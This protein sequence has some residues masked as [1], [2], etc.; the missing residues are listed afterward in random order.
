MSLS[1]KYHV[2]GITSSGQKIEDTPVVRLLL[3]RRD[4]HKRAV[5]TAI[6]DTGF[7]GGV[8][9]NLQ[10]LTFFEGLKPMRIDRL[11]SV[12]GEYVECEVYKVEA[13]II[14]ENNKLVIDIGDVNVYIPTEPDYMGEEVLIGRE[15]LNRLDVT[16]VGKRK[17]VEVRN[18]LQTLE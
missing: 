16:L 8:Y 9:P 4:I 11:S 12:F 18:K 15:V 6:I 1:Y 17:I 5:G 13:S 14:S 3:R 10:I 2:D 7:D